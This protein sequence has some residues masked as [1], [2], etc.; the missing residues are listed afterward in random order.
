M[1]KKLLLFVVMLT[2]L[3]NVWAQSNGTLTVANIKN[4][5]PGYRGSFDLMLDSE[6]LYAGYQ[7]RFD[8][9]SGLTYDGY[10]NGPLI[11]GHTA[12]VSGTTTVT[13]TGKASPTANFTAKTGTLLTIYFTVDGSAT[14]TLSGGRLWDIHFSSANAVDFAMAESSFSVPIGNT[15]T[16]SEDETSAPAAISGVDVT[17]N[18]TLKANVWNTICLPFAMNSTQITSAFGSDAQI[19]NLQSVAYTKVYNADEGEEVIAGVEIA[20]VSVTEMEAHHPYII[21]VS[22]AKTDFSVSGVTITSGT[23]TVNVGTNSNYKNFVGTYTGTTIPDGGLF[24]SNNQFKYSTGVSKLKAFRG[25]FNFRDKL[26]GYNTVS[27]PAIYLDIDGISTGISALNLDADNVAGTYYNVQ[28]QQV[29]QPTK[30]LYIVNGRK[31]IIK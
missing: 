10:A 17:V 1:M 25:Y 11:D 28:G 19:A 6:N 18:R 27:A 30:G 26:Y 23:P 2:G 13:F 24:L 4:A 22:S 29:A 14:G 5:V 8:L 16:L 9:P 3:T 7:F 21:K 15:V 31:V 20:F 12:T